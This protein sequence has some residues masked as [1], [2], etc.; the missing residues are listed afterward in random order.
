MSYI[1]AVPG[2]PLT[3][4]EV[5]IIESL[6]ALLVT[7]SG[8]ALTKATSTTFANAAIGSSTST[9]KQSEVVTLLGDR[10][11]FTLGSAPTA[12]I[13]LLGGHQPQ[14][15]GIDFTGTINGV[16]KTFVYVSQVDPSIIADQYATYL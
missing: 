11:T 12:V 14:I 6:T 7:P 8:Q 4:A 2:T 9:W 13:Y 1:T 10:R 3:S 15:Y 5:A 16:N